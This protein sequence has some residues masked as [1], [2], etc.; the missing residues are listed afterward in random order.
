M[1][2]LITNRI[3]LAARASGSAD[4]ENHCESSVS[5]YRRRLAI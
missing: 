3:V 4:H 5:E 1:I 2:G